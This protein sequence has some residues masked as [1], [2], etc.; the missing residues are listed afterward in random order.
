M[1]A[2]K[3]RFEIVLP[4]EWEEAAALLRFEGRG[5]VVPKGFVT[6]WRT[7]RAD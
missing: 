6:L 5:E 7:S 2:A 1:M 3:K 4:F